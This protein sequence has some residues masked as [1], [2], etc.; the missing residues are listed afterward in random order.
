MNVNKITITDSWKDALIE[1]FD[2]KYFKELL[3][4]IENEYKIK[5]I[6]PNIEN[7]FKTFELCPFDQ[8][9]V[10]I[11]GQD[12]YHGEGQ[13]NGLAFSVNNGVKIPPSLKNIF[14][15]IHNDLKIEIDSNDGDLTRWVKQG[16]LL[17][18]STLTVED[19]KPGSHQKRGWEYFTNAVI[20]KLSNNRSK[21]VFIL[22]GNYAKEKGKI[23]DKN[24]HLVLESA[25]PS[26]FSAY[27]GFFGNKHFSRTNEYLRNNGIKEIDWK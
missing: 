6:Y 20:E 15:E 11:L 25:H 17:L 27:N 21:L 24:K 12:P 7:I 8:I 26:P 14:K 5:K 18:N 16:V 9:K 22:W 10:V 2:K 1:E 3:N 23:I 13:A 19:G 4:H